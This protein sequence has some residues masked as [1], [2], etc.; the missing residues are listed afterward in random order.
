MNKQPS[1]IRRLETERA[2]RIYM[3]MEDC[4]LIITEV[5]EKI[6]DRDFDK[7]P[8]KIKTLISD[9]RMILK[10]MEDDDF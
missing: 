2:M 6:V 5:Y 3:R 4:H 1:D 10:S 8:D 9:L 7:V